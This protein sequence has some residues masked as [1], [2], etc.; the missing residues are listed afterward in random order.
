MK[1]KSLLFIPVAVMSLSAIIG[2]NSGGTTKDTTIDAEID[3]ALKLPTNL[4]G[5]SDLD[6]LPI[7]VSCKNSFSHLL[8]V[9]S[10][11]VTKNDYSKVYTGGYSKLKTDNEIRYEI[12]TNHYSNEYATINTTK[13]EKEINNGVE[14]NFTSKRKDTIYYKYS[15]EEGG[16]YVPKDNI[17]YNYDSLG[18]QDITITKSVVALNINPEI[19]ED[20]PTLKPVSTQEEA[21]E[22]IYNFMFYYDSYK[23]GSD[24]NSTDLGYF[25][26]ENDSSV[27]CYKTN[28]TTKRIENFVNPNI[29]INVTTTE[30][31]VI[32]FVKEAENVWY[33]KSYATCTN[34]YYDKDFAGNI[35]AEPVLVT[36]QKYAST[37][38]YGQKTTFDSPIIESDVQDGDSWLSSYLPKDDRDY[39]TYERVS[40][41]QHNRTLTNITTTARALNPESEDYI[42]YVCNGGVSKEVKDKLDKKSNSEDGYNTLTDSYDPQNA[43]YL[44]TVLHLD[45]YITQ[46]SEIVPTSVHLSKNHL[47]KINTRFA[48][49][50]TSHGTKE[51]IVDET[52]SGYVKFNG[53]GEFTVSRS[54]EYN[55]KV[56][57]PQKDLT[58]AT[59]YVG[60]I[61]GDEEDRDYNYYTAS[62]KSL[63]KGTN[64]S[65]DALYEDEDDKEVYVDVVEGQK[66]NLFNYYYNDNNLKQTININA[67]DR[68]NYAVTTKNIEIEKEL[69]DGTKINI[70]PCYTTYNYISGSISDLSLSTS[71]SIEDGFKGFEFSTNGYINRTNLNYVMV[72]TEANTF[73][74]GAHWNYASMSFDDTAQLKFNVRYNLLDDLDSSLVPTSVILYSGK[75]EKLFEWGG[76]SERE[77]AENGDITLSKNDVTKM[78][79]QREKEDDNHNISIV[80]S[81]NK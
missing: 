30:K 58:K 72:N 5:I 45:N 17:V 74:D 43:L 78:L 69:D 12:E 66:Y 39:A 46:N 22:Q 41:S 70:A 63:A 16:A 59:V 27:Y 60:F 10:K 61:K 38:K 26:R 13:R 35:F 55:I 48:D 23:M 31:T 32:H 6:A 8:G 81:Y 36:T 14:S 29:P 21:R 7:V 53:D 20:Q 73:V 4:V 80:A 52:G 15:E 2:C 54:G 67:D 9:Q 42:F 75:G 51:E 24:G 62:A 77:I 65:F 47:Y 49:V 1:N 33:C 18:D 56:V 37:A 11:N 64:A 3:E 40:D 50:Q 57:V 79:E 68:D 19:A 44:L 25:S 71:S 76:D 28:S 34:S